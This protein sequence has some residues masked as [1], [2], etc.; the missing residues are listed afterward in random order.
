MLQRLNKSLVVAFCEKTPWC[1]HR[2]IGLLVFEHWVNSILPRRA[3]EASQ[4]RSGASQ[5]ASPRL[6]LSRSFSATSPGGGLMSAAFEPSVK[7]DVD[8]PST[9]CQVSS[10]PFFF[11]SE[12]EVSKSWARCLGLHR[13]GINLAMHLATSWSLIDLQNRCR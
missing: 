9:S 8:G 12:E 1:P 7:A 5:G 2:A 4:G 13:Y 6:A 11:F 3:A 10:Q